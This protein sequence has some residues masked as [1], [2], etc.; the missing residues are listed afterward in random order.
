MLHICLSALFAL[1]LPSASPCPHLYDFV[2]GQT[3]RCFFLLCP[4]IS[5]PCLHLCNHLFSLALCC[6]NIN[7]GHLRQLVLPQHQLRSPQTHHLPTDL[8]PRSVLSPRCDV[9]KLRKALCNGRNLKNL[10]PSA[11]IERRLIAAAP[12]E[13]RKLGHTGSCISP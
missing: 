5:L 6:L 11:Q 7:F 2:F 8:R 13:P 4:P 12:T 3:L 1:P 9:H 10:S